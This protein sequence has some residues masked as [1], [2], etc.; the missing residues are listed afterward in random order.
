MAVYC[1]AKREIGHFGD[2][3]PFDPKQEDYSDA[4]GTG[5][6]EPGPDSLLKDGSDFEAD[7]ESIMSG[8]TFEAIALPAMVGYYGEVPEPEDFKSVVDGICPLRVADM[9]Q[10]FVEEYRSVTQD[11]DRQVWLRLV[12]NVG[13]LDDDPWDNPW[14]LQDVNGYAAEA[15]GVGVDGFP[16]RAPVL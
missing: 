1:M 8:N 7:V 13:G 9:M 16:A 14:L 6:D 10:T 15:A 4:V 11:S 5:A 12:R 3:T 2:T